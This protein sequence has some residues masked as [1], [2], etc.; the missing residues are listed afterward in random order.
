MSVYLYI[1][2]ETPYLKV[3]GAP[4]SPNETQSLVNKGH[5]LG[6]LSSKLRTLSTSSIYVSAFSSRMYAY[7]QTQ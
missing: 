3:R 7:T 1:K 6:T 4:K 2:V 5:L